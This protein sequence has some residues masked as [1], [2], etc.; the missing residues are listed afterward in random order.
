MDNIQLMIRFD[1]LE[2]LIKNLE[3]SVVINTSTHL[4]F[5]QAAKYLNLSES[6]LYKLTSSGM[7]IY[8]RPTGKKIYFQKSDLDTWMGQNR[9]DSIE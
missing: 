6:Y 5:E 8:S 3:A 7:I 1:E 2:Q 4:T 9:Q